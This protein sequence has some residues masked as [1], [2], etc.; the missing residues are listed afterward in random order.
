MYLIDL[1]P[2][3]ILGFANKK[4]HIQGAME[5]AGSLDKE[6]SGLNIRFSWVYVNQR[7]LKYAIA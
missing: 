3:Q 1:L 7:E 4:V 6:H 5:P 2:C